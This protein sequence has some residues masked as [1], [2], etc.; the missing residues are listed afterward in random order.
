M[1][2]F[3]KSAAVAL[4][5]FSALGC[6]APTVPSVPLETL[7]TAP[8]SIDVGGR[9]FVLETYLWRDYMP[10]LNEDGS[11]LRAVVEITAVDLQS[12][13]DDVDADK[14]WVILDGDVWETK[15]S[16]ENRPRD[17]EH[18]HQLEKYVS[19]GPRWE[20]GTEVEAVVRVTTQG[21]R[22]YLLRASAQTIHRTE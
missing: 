17:E 1:M 5:C 18:P 15:F 9:V 13:P 21:G 8:L 2:K 7:L 10:P 3:V 16:G 12:F 4:V 6:P 14:L 20:T 11:D 19:G 22:V